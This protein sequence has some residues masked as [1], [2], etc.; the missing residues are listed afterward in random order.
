M[1]LQS[2]MLVNRVALLAPFNP[3]VEVGNSLG[4][5]GASVSFSNRLSYDFGVAG[6]PFL[7]QSVAPADQ[8]IVAY[9]GVCL[10]GMTSFTTCFQQ[11]CT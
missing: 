11:I 4:S 2:V 5:L 6:D 3:V 10:F 9:K 1:S 8:P 7:Y